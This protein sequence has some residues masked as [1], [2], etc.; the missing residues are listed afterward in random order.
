MAQE[1]ENIELDPV[2]VNETRNAIIYLF[3][4]LEVDQFVGILALMSMAVQV[5]NQM[6]Y[7]DYAMKKVLKNAQDYIARQEAASPLNRMPEGR[8]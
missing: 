1:T 5:M 2:A 7:S 4:K 6:G 3:H 8:A